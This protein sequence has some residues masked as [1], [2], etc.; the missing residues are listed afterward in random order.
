MQFHGNFSPW[1]GIA[2]ASTCFVSFLEEISRSI[3]ECIVEN[4][5]SLEIME[6]MHK[7]L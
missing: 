5:S 7:N 4:G 3:S 2:V 1:L 6:N